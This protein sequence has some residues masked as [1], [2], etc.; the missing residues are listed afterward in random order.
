MQYDACSMSRIDFSFYLEMIIS[1]IVVRIQEE[2]ERSEEGKL[3]R[4]N[5]LA[6]R[7]IRI[8]GQLI[9]FESRQPINRHPIDFIQ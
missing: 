4:E 6:D 9:R 1:C 2:E 3:A 8:V 5:S 7:Y